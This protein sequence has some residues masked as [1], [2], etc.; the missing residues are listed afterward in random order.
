MHL[1]WESNPK[2]GA[3][4]KKDMSGRKE[5]VSC[6]SLL[7]LKLSSNLHKWRILGGEASWR[8]ERMLLEIEEYGH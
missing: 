2:C 7:S 8:C 5:G 1:W 3:T 6:P 4:T